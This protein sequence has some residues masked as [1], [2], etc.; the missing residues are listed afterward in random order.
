MK[1]TTYQSLVIIDNTIIQSDGFSTI[2]ITN[3]ADTSLSI[4]QNILLN[5]GEKWTWENDSDTIIATDINI[6][7][8]NKPTQ[9][10]RQAVIE[11]FYNQ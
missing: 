11:K 7:F 9:P 1:K 5:K 10:T 2:R 8:D 4:N 6:R 3:T